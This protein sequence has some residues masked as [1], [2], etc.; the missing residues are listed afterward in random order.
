MTDAVE[1]DILND[2]YTLFQRVL[3]GGVGHGAMIIPTHFF[4][5]IIT[6][7][8]PP[9]G[10]IL[11]AV[12][13]YL[14]DGFPWITWNALKNLFDFQILNRIIYSFV[15]TSLFY[16]PGL[17]YVLSNITTGTPNVPGTL[18]CN[19]YTGICED[20]SKVVNKEQLTN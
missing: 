6:L 3:Y 1:N 4:K 12:S 15:L 7:I 16:L 2:D 9:L 19:P 10:E 20:V 11:N 17:I 18:I 14:V 8:F 13:V 5:V